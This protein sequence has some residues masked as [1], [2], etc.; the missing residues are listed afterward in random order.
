MEAERMDFDPGIV[1]RSGLFTPPERVSA[2]NAQRFDLAGFV[3][4]AQSASY[5]PTSGPAGARLIEMLGELYYRY[6]DAG[7]LVTL[8]YETELYRATRR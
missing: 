6:A 8:V 2:P 7:G 1:D 5:V 3:G 4:R